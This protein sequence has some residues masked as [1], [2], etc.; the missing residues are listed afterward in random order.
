MLTDSKHDARVRPDSMFP[1]AITPTC[2]CGWKGSD[3][4]ANRLIHQVRAELEVDKHLE[5]VSNG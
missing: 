3:Y 5:E 2:S 1:S 4:D